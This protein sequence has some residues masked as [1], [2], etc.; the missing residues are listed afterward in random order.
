[1]NMPIIPKLGLFC[2]TIN[3]NK[4]FVS[5]GMLLHLF[6]NF[7]LECLWNKVQCV[8]VFGAPELRCHWHARNY[9]YYSY[10]N[11][12]QRNCSFIESSIWYRLDWSRSH[13][14][15][16]LS[17]RDLLICVSYEALH[18]NIRIISDEN[19]VETV[20]VCLF[21]ILVTVVTCVCEG[22][23]TGSLQWQDTTRNL[24]VAFR[25]S[26][27]NIVEPIMCKHNSNVFHLRNTICWTIQGLC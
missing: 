16:A 23:E 6:R 1:M 10:H 13:L 2:W 27:L 11:Q 26:R 17:P 8:C 18:T 5:F 24:W 4:H 25:G 20:V 21:E 19:L 9:Y 7:F 14:A 15:P 12:L 22:S 3:D